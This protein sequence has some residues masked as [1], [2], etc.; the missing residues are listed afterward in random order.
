ME[1]NRNFVEKDPEKSKKSS[2]HLQLIVEE[3]L[4]EKS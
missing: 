3:T 4:N 2:K 1:V